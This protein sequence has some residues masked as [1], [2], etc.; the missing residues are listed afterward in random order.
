M[1]SSLRVAIVCEGLGAGGTTIFTHALAGELMRQGV[2]VQVWAAESAGF[3]REEFVAQSIPVSLQDEQGDI[4]E[5]RLAAICRELAD[6]SPTVVIANHCRA[7]FEILRYVPEGVLRVGVLHSDHAKVYCELGRY[8]RWLDHV[9]G[10]SSGIAA[11]AKQSGLFA[12]IPCTAI[13]CGVRT[14]VPAHTGRPGQAIQIVYLGR[15]QRAQKRVHLFVEIWKRLCASGIPFTWT[16]AGDGS[17]MEFLKRGLVSSDPGQQVK[18]AGHVAHRDVAALLAGQDIMLLTS[19]YEGTPLSILEA[20]ACG[21]V[22]VMSDLT[23]SGGEIL[24]GMRGCLVPL[25]P[26][27]GYADAIIALAEDRGRL[28]SLSVQGREIVGKHYSLAL[29]G[30]RW[31]KVFEAAGNGG[32]WQ[33]TVKIE[34]PLAVQWPVRSSR[35]GRWLRRWWL[36]RKSP[37]IA[38]R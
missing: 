28:Q 38:G 25:M 23:T 12:A 10:V 15:L 3:C 30:D 7:S 35:L 29:L 14:E 9:V 6:F 4:L 31:G 5:D 1:R 34:T 17:E 2:T 24:Q 13:P 19:D 32:D 8:A 21:V 33:T 16:I 18:F 20:M 36:K 37:S 26:P 22:P 11:K 27:A